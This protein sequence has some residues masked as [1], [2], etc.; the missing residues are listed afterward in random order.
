MTLL[1]AYFWCAVVT[2]IWSSYIIGQTEINKEEDW[3]PFFGILMSTFNAIFWVFT[4]PL[5]IGSWFA[6]KD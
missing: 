5:Q 6:K 3:N 4:V 2:F 1:E